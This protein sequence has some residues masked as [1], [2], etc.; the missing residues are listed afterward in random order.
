MQQFILFFV[1]QDV[2]WQKLE[3]AV[4]AIQNSTSIK[5]ALEDLYQAVQN[6]CS[7]SFAPLVYSKLKSLTGLLK[8]LF[9][10]LRH[11]IKN[12][13]LHLLFAEAHVQSNLAQF[14][15]ESID[16]CVFLKMMNDCWQSHC[17]QMIL[18]RGIFLYLD[19][20][21]VLQNPGVLSLWDM[22]LDTFKVYIISDPLVQ[23]RTVDGL[24]LLIDKERQGDTVDRSLLKSLLRM[25]SDLGIYHEAFETK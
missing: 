5:S 19:R 4:V 18:I 12:I 17:Q 3:E 21:Y 1:L 13:I 14:L 15:A 2:A 24:L 25:L 23:T 7:H 20:K 10:A 9:I 16:P 8:N 11:S 6:L 22:G